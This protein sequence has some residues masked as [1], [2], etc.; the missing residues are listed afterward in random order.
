MLLPAAG[1]DAPGLAVALGILQNV[2]TIYPGYFCVVL[3]FK[4]TQE[5]SALAHP[6]CGCGATDS[7][8]N[9]NSF[10]YSGEHS[11]TPAALL[12]ASTAAACLTPVTSHTGVTH[13]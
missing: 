12:L 6:L 7:C 11:H 4:L 5:S 9:F 3:L 1:E 2:L 8:A 10:I 13:K